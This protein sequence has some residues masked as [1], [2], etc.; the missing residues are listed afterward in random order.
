MERSDEIIEV[1]REIRDINREHLNDYKA[2]AE[3]SIELQQR[4]VR[5]AESIGKVYRIALIVTAVLI[6]GVIVLIF[7]LMSFLRR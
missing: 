2:A 1:L 6:G 3:R 4:A 7:Y 5:R